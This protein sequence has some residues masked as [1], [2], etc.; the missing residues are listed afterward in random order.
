MKIFV[1]N[2]ARHR[3]LY[4]VCC[5][6]LVLCIL[7]SV[8]IG[9]VNKVYGEKFVSVS[10]DAIL[11]EKIIILDAGHGG[12]DSGAIGVNGVYEKDLNLEYALEIG[13]MLEEKGYI[14]VYTRTDDRMLYTEEEDVFGIRKISDLKN[15]CKVAEK[16]PDSTFI[17][18]HMNSFGA[19]KYSGLQVYYSKENEKSI[20]LANSIQYKVKSALQPE[21][22][23]VVKAAE[24]MYVLENI[25]NTAVLIECGFLTNK[26]ECEKLSEKEYKKELCFSIV[27]GIIEYIEENNN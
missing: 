24:G 19:S 1:V 7:A 4:N 15:R 22:N 2:F 17:S 25:P 3:I 26:D 11:K 8:S 10:S 18:I 21:N 14:I 12:K 27:C 13:K 20:N 5:I 23:R 9:V 6:M 16:Y